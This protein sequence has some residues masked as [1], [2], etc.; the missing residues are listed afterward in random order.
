MSSGPFVVLGYEC[1]N[2]DVRPIRVQEETETVQNPGATGSVA[3]S[4]VFAKRKD[5]GYGT[6]ARQVVLSRTVGLLSD[7]AKKY[8]SLPVF[9]PAAWDDLAFGQDFE[10]NG[11][12]WKVAGLIKERNR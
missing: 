12:T 6:F 2:G 8:I 7:T 4:F 10:Y 1:D 3:G 9:T 5:K 11:Q